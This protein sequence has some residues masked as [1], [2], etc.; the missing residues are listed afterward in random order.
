LKTTLTSGPRP[1][2]ARER[3]EVLVG[4]RGKW[5]GWLFGLRGKR[6]G[7]L[8]WRAGMGWGCFL[9]FFNSFFPHFFSNFYSK[10][11]Q[12]FFKPTFKPHNQSKAHAFNMMHNHLVNS[13]LINYYCIYLKA[14]LII[15]IH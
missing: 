14:S 7:G 1:S 2:A 3:G 5:A 13:K 8:G 6:L 15:Q 4:W 9:F 10:S 11:F 12:K